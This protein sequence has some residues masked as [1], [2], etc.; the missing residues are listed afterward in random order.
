MQNVHDLQMKE[1]EQKKERVRNGTSAIK[2]WQ[3]ARQKQIAQ[4][5]ANN[6]ILQESNEK[7]LAEMKKS[8]NP[9]Q[10]VC[11]NVEFTTTATTPGGKD[12]SRMKQAMLA[13]KAD[14]T[15]K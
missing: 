3:T 8:Q 5:H 12:V 4:Q 11:A 15:Q 10:R 2:E 1:Q 7:E 13:R 14:L 9:W 6:Q